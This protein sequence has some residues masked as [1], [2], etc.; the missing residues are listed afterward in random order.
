MREDK[1][2]TFEKRSMANPML[3]E[4]QVTYIIASDHRNPKY[5]LLS[6]SSHALA[7]LCIQIG[8]KSPYSTLFLLE[9]FA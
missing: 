6:L 7:N 3:V 8:I 9:N 4:I 1:P 5:L 2:K